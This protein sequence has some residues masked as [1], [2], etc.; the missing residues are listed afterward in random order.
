MLVI[1]QV[2]VLLVVAVAMALSLA[3]ALEL[4]GKMRL[5]RDA[6]LAVQPIYYPGF[7]WG[8]VSE[9]LGIALLAGLLLV[10]E[11]AGFWL[12]LAALVALA[13]SHAV[14]WGMTHPVNGF[15]L[16]DTKL[17]GA[18]ARFFATGSPASQDDGDWTV[19]RDR[20]ERSHVIRAVFTMASFALLAAAIAL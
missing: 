10:E 13:A 15:W 7:T 4:P 16:K 12:V 20:W 6:Y 5:D 18:G 11:D 2:L 14:Y 1:Y 3:H 8:G 19:F 9:P 17:A